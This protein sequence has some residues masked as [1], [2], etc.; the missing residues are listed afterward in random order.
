MKEHFSGEY[1]KC[2]G[3]GHIYDYD[4]LCPECGSADTPCINANEIKQNWITNAG[5]EEDIR[6]TKMLD[7]HGD[8]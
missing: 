8:L 7:E 5:S 1:Y 6:L 3:C 4:D 2:T